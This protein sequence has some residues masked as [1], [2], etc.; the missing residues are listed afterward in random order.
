VKPEEIPIGNHHT[1]IISNS[2]G[3][4]LWIDNLRLVDL[5]RAAGSPKDKGS[6]IILRKKLGDKV[7]CNDC[8]FTIYGES[9]VK[10]QRA[11]KMLEE[12]KAVK[13][14]EK[15]EMLLDEVKDKPSHEKVFILER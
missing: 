10:L 13:V 2:E 15:M 4:V 9:T 5:A 3:Y 7:K 14:G 12:E 11:E 1:N 6:G 8:L